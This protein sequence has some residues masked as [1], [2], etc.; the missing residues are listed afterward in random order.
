MEQKAKKNSDD[1]AR[2]VKTQSDKI[3]ELQASMTNDQHEYVHLSSPPKSLMLDI[4][5]SKLLAAKKVIQQLK[6]KAECDRL[7]L[8]KAERRSTEYEAWGR[9]TKA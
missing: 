2:E 9:K 7:A 4:L 5:V 1:M 6:S 8:R 3:K